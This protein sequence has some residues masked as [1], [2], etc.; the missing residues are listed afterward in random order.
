MNK[1]RLFVISA[2][3]GTG[4]T[5]ILKA[6]ME[7]IP[8]LAFSISHT[9]R[10]PRAGEKNGVDYHFV[11]PDEFREMIKRGMFLEHAEVHDNL[12]GTSREAVE[13]QLAEGLDVILDID[14]QGA[15]IVRRDKRLDAAYLFISPP[16]LSELEKRLVG[17]GTEDEK[18]IALRLSNAKDEMTAA[19]KYEYLVINDQLEQAVELFSAIVLAERA[20]ARRLRNG[21]PIGEILI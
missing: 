7:N 5:T 10:L 14:V 21:K 2:P 3:S 11:S 12:Y 9:T 18:R 1:G 17:R 16:S 4:K 20:K 8:S 15:D 19:G 6:V 13:Q